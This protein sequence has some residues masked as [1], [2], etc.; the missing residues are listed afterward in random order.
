FANQPNETDMNN[1]KSDDESVDTPLVSPFP[2][3][4]N[5]SNDGE[6]LNE[7]SEYENAGVL[8]QERIYNSFDRDD[9]AF[10]CMIGFRKYIAYLDPFLQLNIIS[11]NAYNTIKVEG[12]EGFYAVFST[13]ITNTIACR[14][15]HPSDQVLTM[16]KSKINGLNQDNSGPCDICHKAKQMRKPFPLSEHKFK[17]PDDLV[18]LDVWGP[19]K[20]ISK[21]RFRFFLIV[22]DDYTRVVWVFLIKNKT[23]LVGKSPYE[24]VYNAEHSVFQ[25]KTFRYKL[26]NLDQKKFLFLRDVKFYETVIPFKNNSLTKE[27]VFEENGINDL[28]FFD[29]INERNLKSGE[30]N[31]DGG[32]SAAVGSKTG[33]NISTQNSNENTVEAATSNKDIQTDGTN[34]INITGSTSSRKVINENEYATEIGVSEGIQGTEL[35]DD[36]YEYEGEDI[37]SFGH[38]FGWSPEPAADDDVYMSLP[39]EYSDVNEKEVM[40]SP[41][42]SHLRLAFRVLRYLK[43]EPVYAITFKGCDDNNLRVFVD[44]DWA[45]FKVTKRLI[46]RSSTE[47]EFMAMCD[48]CCEVMWIKKI[49]TDLQV[50]IDLPIEM[51]CDNNSVT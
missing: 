25:S 32:D 8:R 46:T 45:K 28:N 20:V 37:E 12:L 29:E 5:D 42:K 27:F 3:S 1:L 36:E 6:V 35:N 7:L 10:Q 43:R 49:L 22:V 40:H 21:D 51:N 14:L 41:M 26:F 19:Y 47:A 39:M 24:L 9:L 13:D 23:V 18:H 31:D 44:S 17:N 33:P 15:G 50:D 11:C 34:S 16:L 38:L 48:V 4:N 2:H 30:L